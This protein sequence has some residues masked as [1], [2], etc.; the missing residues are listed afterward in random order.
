MYDDDVADD[1]FSEPSE[2]DLTTE[3]HVHFY[4]HG[5]LALTLQVRQPPSHV[6]ERGTRS[7]DAREGELSEAAM[8]R[9]LEAHMKREGFAP[10]VWFISDHGNAHLMSRPKRKNYRAEKKRQMVERQ[11]QRVIAAA[12]R[13]YG[14]YEHGSLIAGGFYSHWPEPVKNKIRKLRSGR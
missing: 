9:Q 2:G 7:R 14:T 4:Q 11:V 13:K 8:W 1:D 3:D 10:N 6:G 5:R 12:E